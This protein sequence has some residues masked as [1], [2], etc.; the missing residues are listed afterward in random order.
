MNLRENGRRGIKE[1]MASF[2][3][4]SGTRYILHRQQVNL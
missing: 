4:V 1:E 3:D 2:S